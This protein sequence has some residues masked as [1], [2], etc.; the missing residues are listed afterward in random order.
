MSNNGRTFTTDALGLQ[1]VNAN[2][3]TS[4]TLSAST[5]LS[6]P[7]VSTTTPNSFYS[8]TN[9]L[10]YVDS[11]G[12]A[13]R[14]AIGTNPVISLDVEPVVTFTTSGRPIET[15]EGNGSLR[16]PEFHCV[17]NRYGTDGNYTYLKKNEKTIMDL[18]MY[19]ITTA[20]NP[21]ITTD[22]PASV[23]MDDFDFTSGN[24]NS[25]LFLRKLA[26]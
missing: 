7:T 9:D 2:D 26:A 19:P 21:S 15:S 25:F 24:F 4:S 18:R 16:V 23:E 8:L 1:D 3:I 6:I 5:S 20:M 17:G 11:N 14:V 13:K 10:F 22:L 12:L